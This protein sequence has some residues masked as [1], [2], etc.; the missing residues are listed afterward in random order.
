MLVEEKGCEVESGLFQ[1]KIIVRKHTDMI[2][3][4]IILK[5]PRKL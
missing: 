4:A 2:I 3:M 5:S 1:L